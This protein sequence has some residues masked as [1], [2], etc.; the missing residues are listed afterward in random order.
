MF[1]CMVAF[2]RI[3]MKIL[4]V[5]QT[6]SWAFASV[7]AMAIHATDDIDGDRDIDCSITQSGGPLGPGKDCIFP[8]LEHNVS[9]MHNNWRG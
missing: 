5:S 2:F 1:K 6:L 9:P 7:L 4:F 8:F 3:N